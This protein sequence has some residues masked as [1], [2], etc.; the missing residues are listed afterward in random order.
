MHLFQLSECISEIHE[1][2]FIDLHGFLNLLYQ[3]C[4]PCNNF[5]KIPMSI[6]HQ[7]LIFARTASHRIGD[8][9]EKIH[10]FYDVLKLP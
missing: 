5:S 2:Q 6:F 3:A 10:L 9:E 1:E 7:F 8:G 4:F